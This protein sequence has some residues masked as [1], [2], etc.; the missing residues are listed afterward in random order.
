MKQLFFLVLAIFSLSSQAQHRKLTPAEQQVKKVVTDFY[1]W[2]AGN[3]KKIEGFKLYKGKKVKDTPPYVIDWKV[4]E[5]YFGFIRSKVP[6]LGETFIKNETHFFKQC[7]KGFDANPGEEIASG[8]DY[9]RFVGGQ[10]DP[11]LI[12]KETILAKGNDWD[13]VIKGGKATVY[14]FNR[15]NGTA[16]NKG[17]VE[18]VKEKGVWKIAKTIET[19]TE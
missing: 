3:W 6:Q 10:E 16:T 19:V 11:A 18:I 8:F 2:Y 12:I 1:T 13:I 5:K 4:A 9:D 15:H 17:K 7:Q 14:I